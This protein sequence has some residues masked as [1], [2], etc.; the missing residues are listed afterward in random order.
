M[1]L[2]RYGG[3]TG[4]QWAIPGIFVTL[5]PTAWS[6]GWRTTAVVSAAANIALVS[7]MPAYDD[8]ATL[9]AQAFMMLFVTTLSLVFAAK[10]LAIK[11][12]ANNEAEAVRQTRRAYMLT[13]R[14]RL[15]SA[16][17]IEDILDRAR[18]STTRLIQCARP[19]VPAPV[20]AEHH[21]QFQILHERYQRLLLG[22]SPC[23]WW[24]LG[25]PDGLIVSALR[26]EGIGCDV[27][28]MPLHAQ[29]L[30]LS[31][32]IGVAIKQLTCEA[33]LHLLDCARRDRIS[34]EITVAKLDDGHL[35]QIALESTGYPMALNEDSYERLMVGMGAFGLN[36][37]GLRRRAQLYDGKV[38]VSRLP[39][40]EARIVVQLI[41]KPMQMI[42]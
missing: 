23:E 3:S 7:I 17:H 24:E 30:P 22:L 19:F 40:D 18:V 9:N 10:T 14:Q 37:N 2:G 1:L 12:H 15:A 35:I 27:L 41:D 42:A 16:N 39:E 32:E 6:Y 34:M 25:N 28:S 26:G 31:V 38:E 5:I 33:T 20:L 29:T 13:E 36:E 21:C 4:Q 8:Y 11:Q